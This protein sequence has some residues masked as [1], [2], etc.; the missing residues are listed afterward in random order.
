MNS[1]I[2]ALYLT[3]KTVHCV[4]QVGLMKR[5][6]GSD[7]KNHIKRVMNMLITD[8]LHNQ[9]NRSGTHGKH[10]FP[11]QLMKFLKGIVSSNILNFL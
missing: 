6:G 3:N 8:D 4:P 1:R 11:E 9:M 10:K 5:E 2:V 7:L